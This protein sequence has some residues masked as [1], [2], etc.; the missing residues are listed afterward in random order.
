MIFFVLDAAA[1]MGVVRRRIRGVERGELCPR[2][3]VMERVHDGLS[4]GGRVTVFEVAA[5][6]QGPSKLDVDRLCWQR[7]DLEGGAVEGNC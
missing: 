3:G 2:P 1:V 7:E 4:N 5:G 6:L